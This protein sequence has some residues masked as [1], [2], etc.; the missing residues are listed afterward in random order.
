MGYIIFMT[1]QYSLA[2]LAFLSFFF[3]DNPTKCVFMFLYQMK[4]LR[5]N[6]V[7]WSLWIS[8]DQNMESLS[9]VPSSQNSYF[10]TSGTCLLVWLINW[11][12]PISSSKPA[13]GQELCECLPAS[14]H[15]LL[16]LFQS[17]W[18]YFSFEN[19]ITTS[20]AKSCYLMVRRSIPRPYGWV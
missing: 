20:L 4:K 1:S 17:R 8:F 5:L 7:K 6:E 2:I 13:E 3:Y 19:V 11:T 18:L 15:L 16:P 12:D 9:V 10:V 14:C